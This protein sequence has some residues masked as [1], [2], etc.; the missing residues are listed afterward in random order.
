MQLPGAPF[1]FTFALMEDTNITTRTREP[2]VLPGGYI[3]VPTRLFL[4]ARD[5]SEFAG[6]LAHAM[7]H[8]FERHGTRQATR[9]ALAQL[10][11]D[12]LVAQGGFA[13]YLAGRLPISVPASLIEFSNAYEEQA[14]SV[15]VK[16]ASAAGYDAE[17]LLRYL[18][19]THAG[20]PADRSISDSRLDALR[21]DLQTPPPGSNDEFLRL[22]DRLRNRHN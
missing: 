7:A 17:G 3:F 16:M 22:Q 11:A 2:L 20:D 5:E 1:L 14:D 13:G 19:R 9:G 18:S 6:V 4:T 8:S 21:M 10:T 12:P 15:A